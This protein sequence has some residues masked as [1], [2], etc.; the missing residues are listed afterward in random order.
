MK[1]KKTPVVPEEETLN[2]SMP[3]TGDIPWWKYA[4]IGRDA[5]CDEAITL[6]ARKGLHAGKDEDDVDG[7]GE[8]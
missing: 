7:G 3:K 6:S 2:S 5:L 4:L 1:D 8:Q